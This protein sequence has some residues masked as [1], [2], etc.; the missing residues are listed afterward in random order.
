MCELCVL[1]FGFCELSVLVRAAMLAWLCAP[2][3]GLTPLTMIEPSS[4][5]LAVFSTT[6]RY[7]E[8]STM[9]TRPRSCQAW[10]RNSYV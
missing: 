7:A 8:Y 6:L 3:L 2:T 5:E 1:F 4:E 10:A 9:S